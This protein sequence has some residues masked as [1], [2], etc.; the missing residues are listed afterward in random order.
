MGRVRVAL[1]P[2]AASTTR[3]CPICGE[4]AGTRPFCDGCG[5]N[6]TAESQLPTRAEWESAHPDA[7]ARAAVKS[8]QIMVRRRRAT[9]AICGAILVL[10]VLVG[11]VLVARHD[12][13]TV[14][15]P[16]ASMEPTLKTGQRVTVEQGGFTPA[17]GDIVVFHPPV[18]ALTSPAVCGVTHKPQQSCPRPTSSEA[19]TT[20][21]IKRVVAGPGDTISIVD[22]HVYL[23]GKR[24]SEPFASFQGCTIQALACNFTTPLT[25][26]P[27]YY[28]V[29]GD[30]RDFSDDSRFWGPVPGSWIVGRV[31]HCA[32]F[33]V[34]CGDGP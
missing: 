19:T 21:Y 18:G 14:T 3:V 1:R 17:V 11:V 24:Q 34:L 20:S 16:S 23:D 10:A 32:L 28:F 4:P 2:R 6:L 12:V 22:G 31:V 7:A 15:V 13:R 30:N 27:G 33:N 26:A 5:R 29:L 9:I 8:R 25:I